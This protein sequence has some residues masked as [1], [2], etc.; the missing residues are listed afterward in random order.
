MAEPLGREGCVGSGLTWAPHAAAPQGG[1]GQEQQQQHLR[2]ECVGCGLGAQTQGQGRGCGL[3]AG[4]SDPGSGVEG[5]GCRGWGLRPGV[6]D[7]G[8]EPP[9]GIREG[10]V[11]LPCGHSAA[12]SPAGTRQLSPPAPRSPFILNRRKWA[13]AW[14]VLSSEEGQWGSGLSFSHW[15]AVPTASPARV[16]PAGLG[17]RRVSQ[18][19]LQKHQQVPGMRARQVKWRPHLKPPPAMLRVRRPRFLNAQGRW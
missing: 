4:D 16:E 10:M 9:A 12:L 3:R 14:S 17:E 15:V 6:R 2:G 18:L 13:A 8:Q 11:P 19:R 5:V 1:D 7:G